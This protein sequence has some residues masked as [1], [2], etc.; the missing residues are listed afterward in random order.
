MAKCISPSRGADVPAKPELP[1]TFLNS[2]LILIFLCFSKAQ[3]I[4]KKVMYIEINKL[5]LFTRNKRGGGREKPSEK[6]PYLKIRRLTALLRFTIS[7]IE[8]LGKIAVSLAKVSE[9]AFS[10][11]HLSSSTTRD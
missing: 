9:L 1:S 5:K 3:K 6:I 4:R 11:A 2:S 10:F 7:H 8:L